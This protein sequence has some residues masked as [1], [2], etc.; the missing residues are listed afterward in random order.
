M[1][2]LFK[3]GDK[4]ICIRTWQV[5]DNKGLEGEQ[6]QVIHSPMYLI[7][8]SIVT[9]SHLVYKTLGE[10]GEFVGDGW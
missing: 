7:L 10:L 8:L 1:P 2:Q 6:Y 5:K 9:P 3:P 4:V